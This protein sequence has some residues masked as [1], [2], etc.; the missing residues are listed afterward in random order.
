[1]KKFL[2]MF[3]IISIIAAVF[4]ITAYG[5]IAE[6]I[7]I[8]KESEEI[9]EET[10][11][12]QTLSASSELTVIAEDESKRDEYTK[13]FLL[14]DKSYTVVQYPYEIHYKNS[15]GKF[16]EI[17]N[18]FLTTHT[19]AEN[20]QYK[21][22]ENSF[23]FLF[24]E[25]TKIGSLMTISKDNYKISFSL[26]GE[27]SL[28]KGFVTESEIVSSDTAS[29]E[30]NIKNSHISTDITPVSESR[31]QISNLNTE[32]KQT[33]TLSEAS[34]N[35]KAISSVIYENILPDT[36]IKYVLC[37]TSV[38]ENIIINEP[39]GGYVYTF[40]LTADNLKP[41]FCEDGSIEM[42]D[43]DTTVFTI[44]SPYMFDA[45]GAISQN[46]V[47]NLKKSSGGYIFTVI[48]DK[49]WIE[50]EDRVFPVTID[51]AIESKQTR[52]KIRIAYAEEGIN[53]SSENHSEVYMDVGRFYE[54][55]GSLHNSFGYF[56]IE[57]PEIENGAAIISAQVNLFA[58]IHE[59][60]GTSSHQFNLHALTSSFNEKYLGW[61]NKPSHENRITDYM[62]YTPSK[63]GVWYQFDA[64]NI[65]QKWYS[66]TS[67]Q[68]GFCIKGNDTN[69]GI[70]KARF[71]SDNFWNADTN[72][73]AYPCMTVI[74]RNT[75]GLEDYWSYT[76][77]PA[78]RGGNLSVNNYNGNLVATHPLLG[79]DGT[80]MPVDI[81]LTYNSVYGN[82]APGKSYAGLGWLLNYDISVS[83]SGNTAALG[84]DYFYTDSDGTKHY[85]HKQSD[86][87]RKDEDG[88]GLSLVVSSDTGYT[89]TDKSGI[90]LIFNT[91]GWLTK[92]KN[93]NGNSVN[94]ARDSSNRISAITDG[95]DRT[96]YVSYTGNKISQIVSPDGK[97]TSFSYSDENLVKIN[98]YNNSE[99]LGATV[100]TYLHGYLYQTKTIQSD[101]TTFN[102]EY[103][104]AT[105]SDLGKV[106]NLKYEKAHNVSWAINQRYDF[107]YNY[108]ETAVVD[109]QNRKVIHQFDTFGH[110]TGVVDFTDFNATHGIFETTNTVDGKVNSS[111]NKIKTE[112]TNQKSNTN[113]LF[114]TAFDGNA[115]YW[116]YCYDGN[117]ANNRILECSSS[118]GRT[119]VGSAHIKR[120]KSPESGA[121]WLSFGQEITGLSEGW[122]T[123]SGYISTNGGILNGNGATILI[124]QST[125]E[126][127]E[128]VNSYSTPVTYTAAGEWTKVCAS[129]YLRTGNKLK[130]LIG[131]Q[132]RPSY[133]E[134]WFDDL[135]L[136]YGETPNSRNLLENSSFERGL[137]VGYQTWTISPSST[138][139]GTGG[140]PY[141]KGYSRLV[142]GN[143]GKGYLEVSSPRI[144]VNG[145]VGDAFSF[146][147]WAK[148]QSVA[149]NN[150]NREVG[151]GSYTIPYFQSELRF[152]N[153]NTLVQK[154]YVNYNPNVSD[155]Q[156]SS[157][158]AIAS[159]AYTHV[160][161]VF[162]YT[163]NVNYTYFAMPY[164]YKEAYG[165][166]FTYDK[167]GNVANAKDL[168]EKNSTFVYSNNTLA[169]LTSPSGSNYTYSTNETT[170]NLIAANSSSGQRYSFEYDDKGNPVSAKVS[171]DNFS[172]L[173]AGATPA[174]TS[175]KL[176]FIRNAKTGLAIDS[177]NTGSGSLIKNYNF[178]YGS[179]Y[180]RWRVFLDGD[181]LSLQTVSNTS[182][183]AKA[184]TNTRL[185]LS[186]DKTI[187][188]VIDNGDGT[189]SLK[190]DGKY[191]DGAAVSEPEPK[192]NIAVRM[193]NAGP[194]PTL[195]Q[196]WY[197]YAL[198]KTSAEKTE[199]KSEATYTSDKNNVSTITDSDG[200]TVSY[201][202]SEET[203]SKYLLSSE[204][205]AAGVHT[206][207]TYDKNGRATKTE[208]AGKDVSYTYDSADRLSSASQNSGAVKYRFAYDDWSRNTSVSIESPGLTG[209]T[210]VTNTF[211]SKNLLTSAAY[212]NGQTVYYT[213]DS[214]DRLISKSFGGTSDSYSYIY[215]LNGKLGII[216]DAVNETETRYFYDLAG[217]LSEISENRAGRL[218][219]H[220]LYNYDEKNRLQS[221]K[222]KFS[223]IGSFDFSAEYGDASKG[224]D[225]GR[226]YGVSFNGEKRLGYTFDHLGR[227]TASSLML[228]GGTKQT[229]YFYRNISDTQTTTRL[230]ELKL[231]DGTRYLYTY[232]LSGNISQI[233]KEKSG[234]STT[235]SYT[236][237]EIGQLIREND[238][239][240]NLTVV[241]SYD[242]GGN[243]TAKNIYP[244]TAGSIT[245][246]PLQTIS[247]SYGGE[248]AKWKDQ[249][250]NY[251]GQQITYDG[252]GNPLSYRGMS[253]TW[254]AGRQLSEITKNDTAISY[255][256]NDSGIRTE[257]LA[258]GV[259]TEYYIIGDTIVAEKRSDGIKIIYLTDESGIKIGF[260]IS[261]S[262]ADGTYYYIFNAQGD[263]IGIYN[264][265]GEKV[266]EY[267]YDSWGKLLSVTGSL[268]DSIGEINPIRYRGYYYDAET[269]FYYLQSRYYDPEICRFL[270]IDSV[271]GGN[272]S[273]LSFNLFTY[274]GNNPINRIDFTG[275]SFIAIAGLSILICG[276]LFCC[277]GSSSV[278]ATEKTPIDPSRPPPPSSGYVP[279]KK[280]P[281][282]GK[283]P[284]PNGSGKGWPSEG[285]GVWIPDNKQHGGPGWTEQFPGGKHKHH[286]PDGHVR[287]ISPDPINLDPLIGTGLVITGT[288]AITYIIINDITGV[289]VADDWLLGPAGELITR[290]GILI[291]G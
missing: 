160:Q 227:K 77:M 185:T 133:G 226:V 73:G 176:Y 261:G 182:L 107:T 85:F 14:E 170:R 127:T 187:F 246:E 149:L 126:N 285:G 76:S 179:P 161:F 275:Q 40:N 200:G 142:Y 257:K 11:F 154:T 1:M 88:L 186:P 115:A 22:K 189:I 281:T 219:T 55:D 38:K 188:T 183:Y 258:N 268:V 289:G 220:A 190:S 63:N 284:N 196:K 260:T 286:Y 29:F 135:Q 197:F 120:S 68:Y 180:Q 62:T 5:T 166:S 124:Q 263:V 152:Y 245:A 37:G 147:A 80:L 23:N 35:T 103:V 178:V 143:G 207:F 32:E 173:S 248:T 146:G 19:P 54:D 232:D 224:Y 83:Y 17:D 254:H 105:H 31:A 113:Y 199:L 59:S 145:K 92:I 47:Y 100:F 174:I 108:N 70:Y 72:S 181:K 102:N 46:V 4:P 90:S 175:G 280:N 242:N 99:F 249:L 159:K 191:L 45:K 79:I 267:S 250:T 163:G 255:K 98:Y 93:P 282:T 104:T 129:V 198:E 156:F 223:D 274:C 269:G 157:K 43:E 97:S 134:V 51:P 65:V 171:G 39:T 18:S 42:K 287:E 71:V 235:V 192:N 243:L 276:I 210:L 58:N 228:P 288:A 241:Y 26:I 230:S 30:Y 238:E 137:N 177:G 278:T 8:R 78:G 111:A 27:Q 122:Y 144:P 84:Y 67:A 256:Y 172:T 86:G 41:S 131:F 155:W 203:G 34:L 141:G 95:A 225:P 195:S 130:I 52:S 290:G 33:K 119:A 24:A 209:A 169:K 128:T 96:Y 16:S 53:A 82:I 20:I 138:A 139:T 222:L 205:D 89:I 136:E 6:N 194:S 251:N 237:D 125:S 244:Y 116:T 114:N 168:A 15:A 64:T 231:P 201:N 81:K 3:L 206:S 21:G 112:S 162:S 75:A 25:N 211:N 283:V 13:Y 193:E 44:P 264:S 291:F 214:L 218:K 69:S 247:Y 229:E 12:D 202:Y 87:S 165:Q 101:G 184:Q 272:N 121:G 253:M 140:N 204:T 217:R 132:D 240:Q 109:N 9:S 239:S 167:N 61:N 212:G 164:I 36:D 66:G 236:Y 208:K 153:G 213:Y 148:G 91:S 266:V 270:N 94:I 279:P 273:L 259:K 50:S 48:A 265:A 277:T 7:K 118:F 233:T 28:T 10:T 158:E 117:N 151:T 216:K 110:E 215:D 271:L 74:Y 106:I 60:V 49:N 123:V 262:S 150:H 56:D 234:V 221:Y 57:L 2:A 252:I